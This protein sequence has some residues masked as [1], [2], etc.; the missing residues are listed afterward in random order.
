MFHSFS[1]RGLER[2]R[3]RGKVGEGAEIR[4]TTKTFEKKFK[5]SIY[6]PYE[7]VSSKEYYFTMHVYPISICLMR[8]LRN[9]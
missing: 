2:E 9:I 3:N 6:L 7:T 4:G 8:R 1:E 5:Y